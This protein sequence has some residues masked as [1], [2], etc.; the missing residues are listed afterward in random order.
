MTIRENQIAGIRGHGIG[1][2]YPGTLWGWAVYFWGDASG[3]LLEGNTI[4]LDATGAPTLGSVWGV[5]VDNFAFY[6]IEDVTLVDNR[7]GGHLLEGVRIVPTATMR[8]SRNEIFENGGLGI[9]LI[10]PAFTAGVT[11]NDALDADTGGNGLQNYPVLSLAELT[12]GGVHIVGNLQ[13]S[14]GDPFTVDFF[15]SPLCDGSGAW[16]RAALPGLD[17]SADRCGWQCGDRCDLA[18][19]GPGRLAGDGDG[20]PGHDW[21]D[22]G[23]LH[24]R[25]PDRGD[26]C[27]LLRPRIAQ[28]HRAAGCDR[29][30]G[31]GGGRSE[32]R[33]AER[34]AVARRA[35]RDLPR[36]AGPRP[37]AK[38]GG[39]L[40]DL[41]LGGA[42][43]R[44][45]QFGQIFFSG[46]GG[47]GV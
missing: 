37:R 29:G 45:N 16:G 23:V 1:P 24:L 21:R 43:G 7:I 35:I 14:P 31:F 10:P 11:P 15:A 32:R 13:S 46:T 9:D 6:T 34:V 30:P 39:S 19:R 22:F 33:F 26:R 28:L 5:N 47:Q 17:Q 18:R 25:F 8:L 41:C 36:V 38:P 2:T 4:G 27:E 20:D 44:Y 12:A 42:I 40:G 3:I